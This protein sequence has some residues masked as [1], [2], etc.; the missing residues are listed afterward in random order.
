MRAVSVAD[1]VA[2]TA[3][4]GFESNTTVFGRILQGTLPAKIVFEDDRVLGFCDISPA[5]A[6]HCLVIPKRHIATAR[7]L[8]PSDRALVEHMIAAANEIAVANGVASPETARAEGQLSFGFH[9]RP[10]IM[11]PHLHLHV[12][13][14]MPAQSWLKRL[15][16]PA[17]HG[18]L[19][20][21]P[22]AA[23]ESYCTALG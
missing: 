6:M 11:I 9:L 10:L 17:G 16:F 2:N 20:V 12:I 4:A 8:T 15:I 1:A 19:Y 22:E 7:Q 23:L 18:M 5:S 3:R 14:P 13:H 21:T